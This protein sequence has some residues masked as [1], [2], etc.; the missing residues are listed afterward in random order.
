M[1]FTPYDYTDLI[2]ICSMMFLY[3]IIFVIYYIKKL[4][5][6]IS[7]LEE[8]IGSNN[9]VI[10]LLQKDIDDSWD[11]RKYTTPYRFALF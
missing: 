1:V 8:T 5:A 6:K 7:L 9:C 3:L 10:K 2:Y 11:I 4:R